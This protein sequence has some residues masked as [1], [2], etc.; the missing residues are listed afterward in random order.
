MRAK[1]MIRKDYDGRDID[2][3]ADD[4]DNPGERWF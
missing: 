4:P 1:Y 2:Q 3:E